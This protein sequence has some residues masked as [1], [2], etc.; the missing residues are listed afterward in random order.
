MD[1]SHVLLFMVLTIEMHQQLRVPTA[2]PEDLGLVS[3]THPA[4]SQLPIATVSGDLMPLTYSG[5]CMHAH[6]HTATQ[7]EFKND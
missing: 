3:S 4:G 2:L 6:K 5:T 7:I 1:V